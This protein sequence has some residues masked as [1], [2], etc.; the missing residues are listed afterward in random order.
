MKK[1]GKT[2]VQQMS[3]FILKYGM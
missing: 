1:N 3:L 2:Y